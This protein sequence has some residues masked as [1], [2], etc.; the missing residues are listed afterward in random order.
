VGTGR[1]SG[2]G[3]IDARPE[4]VQVGARNA[5]QEGLF[6]VQSAVVSTQ[7]VSF[8]TMWTRLVGDRGRWDAGDDQVPAL[9][10]EAS[11]HLSAGAHMEQHDPVPLDGES[12]DSAR[13]GQGLVAIWIHGD[14]PVLI[15]DPTKGL[16]ALK[17]FTKGTSS[18]ELREALRVAGAVK[19]EDPT[20]RG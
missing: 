11:A 2:R 8:G 5:R 16:R 15:C 20:T 6:A 7:D 13:F 19:H 17:I 4:G 1:P 10:V 18:E 9:Q 14:G 12:A 3:S